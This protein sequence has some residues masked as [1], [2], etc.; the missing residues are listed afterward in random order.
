MPN[1]H[2]TVPSLPEL[3]SP[4]NNNFDIYTTS[5]LFDTKP[6]PTSTTMSSH[7]TSSPD[8]KQSKASD[9]SSILSTST[10][11]SMTALLKS[12]FTPKSKQGKPVKLEDE[13]SPGEKQALRR[14]DRMDPRILA[15]IASLK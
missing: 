11:S 4:F 5:S 13:L 3:P 7:Q 2:R 6:K 12:K 8:R 1:I 14:Q 9:S 10:T 15:T